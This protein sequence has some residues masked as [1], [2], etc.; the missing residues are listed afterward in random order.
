MAKSRSAQR[1]AKNLPVTRV[2]FAAISKKPHSFQLIISMP[3]TWL[4]FFKLGVDT[5]AAM[6]FKRSSLAGNTASPPLQGIQPSKLCGSKPGTSGWGLVVSKQPAD[7]RRAGWCSR[8]CSLTI[9][10]EGRETQTAESWRICD[11]K[12]AD[13]RDSGELCVSI[14]ITVKFV[15]GNRSGNH[16][17]KVPVTQMIPWINFQAKKPESNLST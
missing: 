1:G 5:R 4:R 3:S 6:L 15:S 7:S 2:Q 17:V 8:I 12:I 13:R 11:R 9:E 16:V 10:F 14:P